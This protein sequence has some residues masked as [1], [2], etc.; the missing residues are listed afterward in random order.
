M[1]YTKQYNIYIPQFITADKRKCPEDFSLFHCLVPVHSFAS[2]CLEKVIVL[3]QPVALSATTS[4]PFST[5][6]CSWQIQEGGREGE[7]KGGRNGER[8]REWERGRERE[9]E[10]ERGRERERERE[11][12][13]R[14]GR[15]E[16]KQI[17][18]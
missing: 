17:L 14:S 4:F 5:A 7:G 8:G 13:R 10:W 3:V 15:R 12:E 1:T 2:A 18:L 9:R 16:R 11:R 6:M